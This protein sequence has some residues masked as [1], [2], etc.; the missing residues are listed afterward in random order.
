MNPLRLCLLLCLTLLHPVAL[1]QTPSQR[2][3]VLVETDA[4]GDPDDEQSM[5]R[6]LLY[7][8]EWDV[9][10]ILANRPTARDGENRNT[11]RTGI[12]IVRRLVRAY[13]ECQPNLALHDPRYPTLQA[14]LDVT[15]DATDSSEAG[16]QRIIEAIDSPDP[17]PLW[18]SDWG[19]DRGSST[20]NLRR[21]LDQVLRERGP[22]GYARFKNR[23]RLSSTDAFGPHT[24]DIHPPFPLWVDTWRPEI[25]GRRWYHQF[26]RIVASAGG[27][28]PALHLLSG[29]GPLGALY[30]TNT[31]PRWKEGD[32]LSFIYWI[33]TGLGDPSDPTLGGWGGRLAPR[34]DAGDRPYYWASAADHWKGVTHRDQTLVR[35]ADAIQNDFRARL[36]WCVK[37]V[38]AANH[39]PVVLLE[40]PIHRTVRAGETVR[41]SVAASSDPD[42]Q[43]LTFR[44][45]PYPE[46]G[47]GGVAPALTGSDSPTASWVAPDVTRSVSFHFIASV[48]DS[49]EPP[50]TRYARV[51]VRVDPR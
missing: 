4:G 28:D 15:L 21:A 3:R 40:G 10:G 33:P 43:P 2:L 17:R 18:Y 37:P 39:P 8:N 6:F 47:T 48:T 29:R 31:S 36:D 9:E 46:A 49:G 20:N 27:F 32:S 5:V 26:S 30:P 14:L 41:L 16:V 35:W 51:V 25:D 22:E 12:G 11:E 23:L 7:A 42:G 50:L 44:W 45:E 19:S 38:R 34:S 13:G 24:F 1:A